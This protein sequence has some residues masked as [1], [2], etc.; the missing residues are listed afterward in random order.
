MEDPGN[1]QV[2]YLPDNND[3]GN[4]LVERTGNQEI[5]QGNQG[6]MHYEMDES[7]LVVGN[8]IEEGLR[9]RIENGEYV[10]FAR[11]L[12][13]DRDNRMELVNKNGHTYFVPASNQGSSDNAIISNFP[14]GSRLSR[15]LRIFTQISTRKNR[16]N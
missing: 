8:Y 13:R 5:G 3:F 4:T 9:S 11:L 6:L 12:P 15:F 2:N 7:Y 16:L 1:K 14:D 10:D